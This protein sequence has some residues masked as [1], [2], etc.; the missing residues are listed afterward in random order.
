MLGR[1]QKGPGCVESTVRRAPAALKETV[2][3][4][5]EGG[6]WREDDTTGGGGGEK[7][8][9]AKAGRDWKMKHG[10][11]GAAKTWCLDSDSLKNHCSSSFLCYWLERENETWIKFSCHSA[12]SFYHCGHS[13]KPLRRRHFADRER[14]V[15][16]FC[17]PRV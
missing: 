12:T 6:D 4:G 8:A 16:E 1:E 17:P 2:S 15:K 7:A 5:Q 9:L 3:P 14:K 13:A 11:L 10:G